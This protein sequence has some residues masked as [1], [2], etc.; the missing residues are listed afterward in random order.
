MTDTTDEAEAAR[1]KAELRALMRALRAAVPEEERL[2]LARAVE[3]G[4]FA[5]PDMRSARTV[6][7][8]YSFGSEVETSGMAERIHSERKRLLLPYLEAERM[9]A[10]EVLPDD[11]LVPSAYGPREPARR[12]AVDPAEVD[13]VIAPGLAFDRE[14]Y[15]LG[16]G[17]GYYDRYLH[18]MGSRAVRIGIGFAG[19]LVERVPRERGDERLDLIVTNTGVVDLRGRG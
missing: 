13:V 15:R 6:L 5:L 19:Q 14:G 17:G 1:H 4:L 11:E 8:F 16:Y 7:L 18:R 3:E 10:G 2:R 12:V 9:E